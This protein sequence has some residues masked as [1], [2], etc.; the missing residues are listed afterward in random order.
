MSQKIQQD[1][2]RRR[3]PTQKV[4]TQDTPIAGLSPDDD[5][6]VKPGDGTGQPGQPAPIPK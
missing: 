5:I 6:G 4:R 1:H 3:A 2:D